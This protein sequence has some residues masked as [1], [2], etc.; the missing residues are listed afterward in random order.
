MTD[1]RL[2]ELNKL[3]ADPPEFN[4][5]SSVQ[6]G[7]FVVGKLAERYR[8]QVSLKRSAYGGTTAVVVVPREMVVEP[9]TSTGP[10]EALSSETTENGLAVRQPAAVGATQAAESA[11]ASGTAELDG[12]VSVSSAPTGSGAAPA[13]VAVPSPAP[14]PAIG[15]PPS[16]Q[17]EQTGE[18]WDTAAPKASAFKVGDSPAAEDGRPGP[19][20]PENTAAPTDA[21]AEGASRPDPAQLEDQLSVPEISSTPSGLPVRVPQANLAPPLRTDEP[22]IDAEAD[23]DEQEAPVRPPE[24]VLRIMGSYQRGVRRGRSDAAKVLGNPAAEGEDEQ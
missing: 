21:G 4:L 9:G 17:A 18:G 5:Q 12:P 14:E 15:E 19:A 24:E 10:Q 23:E 13:L 8:V 22:L 7:L 3:I 20:G 11:T 2:A 6:L 1:E 16:E